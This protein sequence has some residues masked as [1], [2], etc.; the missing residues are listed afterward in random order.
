[1]VEFIKVTP[2]VIGQGAIEQI[3]V[4]AKADG[5]TKALI[6]A[7]PF[8]T[9]ATERVVGLL[10]A[11]GIDSV[12]FNGVV[13][14]PTDTSVY[15]AYEL[16]KKE[17]G[18]DGIVGLGGGSAIDTAKAVNCC[19]NN[20][21]PLWPYTT[22]GGRKPCKD[23]LP[24]Y[25]ISSTAGTGAEVTSAA[26]ISFT[27]RGVKASLRH[28]NVTYAK[29]AFVDPDMSKTMP[30]ALTVSTGVDALCHAA[31][32]LT[33]KVTNPISDSMAKEAIRLIYKYL[34]LVVKEPENMEY[35]EQ[36]SI[37]AMLAGQAFAV[38][39]IHVGHAFGHGLG[40]VLHKPHG[41]MVGVALPYAMTD[42]ADVYPERVKEIGELLG[43]DFTGCDTPEAIAAKIV[44]V[45]YDFYKVI[46]HPTLADLGISREDAIACYPAVLA[47]TGW[48]FHAKEKLGEEEVKEII[49]RIYDCN[50]LG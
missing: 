16:L 8:L 5:I 39:L 29:W 46:G 38:T 17:G 34:P 41:N 11:E 32:A 36:M 20:E 22:A 3:G 12:V 7:D 24:L 26:V 43:G 33:V 30:P 2:C 40:A 14:D 50:I 37:A 6:V 44:E 27:E 9:E 18:I 23:G 47:D 28:D 10:K 25:L 13:P 49:G 31:E 15:E 4:K 21:L 1:M 35:R 42:V 45:I 19:I 48:L